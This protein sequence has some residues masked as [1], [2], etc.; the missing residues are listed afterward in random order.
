ML[1][2]R[3][4]AIRSRLE[5]ASRF[6]APRVFSPSVL[7]SRPALRQLVASTLL[8]EIQDRRQFHPDRPYAPAGVFSG[9]YQRKIIDR[10]VRAPNGFLSPSVDIAPGRFGFAVPEKVAICVRRKRRR[11]VLFARRGTGKGSRARR[12]YNYF[13]TI[14]C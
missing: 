4:D 2:R 1:K 7:I 3:R 5:N 9:V 11:E 13:S 6:S 14:N 12:K 8:R 10:P